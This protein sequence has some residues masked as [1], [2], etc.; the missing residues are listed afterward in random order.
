MGCNFL[1]TS[2]FSSSKY[3][4]WFPIIGNPIC[5]LLSSKTN[6]QISDG[7]GTYFKLTH[8]LSMQVFSQKDIVV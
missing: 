3:D 8:A 5:I 6:H 4:P 2:K 7:M 1:L